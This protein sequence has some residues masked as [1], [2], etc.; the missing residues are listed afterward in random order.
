MTRHSRMGAFVLIATLAMSSATAVALTNLTVTFD[1]TAGHVTTATFTIQR[2]SAAAL[3]AVPRHESLAIAFPRW[4]FGINSGATTRFTGFLGLATWGAGIDTRYIK[5]NSTLLVYGP[6]P[7][8]TQTTLQF[9]LSNI[10]LPY[11]CED[12]GTYSIKFGED[13]P[14]ITGNPTTDAPTGC[15]TAP[16]VILSPSNGQVDEDTVLALSSFDI[17]FEDD[18]SDGIV[19]MTVSTP[20]GKV[21]ANAYGVTSSTHNGVLVLRGRFD[22]IMESLQYTPRKDFNGVDI[23]TIVVND[24]DF[25]GP[26]PART[27]AV[28]LTITVRAVNDAPTVVRPAFYEVHAAAQ[29]PLNL[30]IADV[31]GGNGIVQVS[32]AVVRGYISVVNTSSVMAV[33]GSVFSATRSIAFRSTV[34]VAQATLSTLVYSAAAADHLT[35]YGFLQDTLNVTVNDTGNTGGGGAKI[36]TENP[37][38]YIT[39]PATEEG[40]ALLTAQWL[41]I[42]PRTAIAGERVAF[43]FRGWK[44]LNYGPVAAGLAYGTNCSQWVQGAEPAN[45]TTDS[46]GVTT[47][48]LAP[49]AT[50][51]FY[52]CYKYHGSWSPNPSPYWT[53]AANQVNITTVRDSSV[54]LF[55]YQSC[56]AL[57]QASSLTCGCFL[58][59]TTSSSTGN[60]NVPLGISLLPLLGLKS[61]TFNQGCCARATVVRPS[62]AIGSSLQWGY[63]S[64]IA[65]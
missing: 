10:R 60:T 64:E 11:N 65:S 13:G 47:V 49:N 26:G 9:T 34:A 21:T 19:E 17:T 42:A 31:D 27:T 52:L 63:C 8:A 15:N 35:C 7:E 43:T 62:F 50:G 54:P 39:S 33:G 3:V 59:D 48:T 58:R 37:A 51:F 20:N 38:I 46:F 2:T 22:A 30:S 5:T 14:S 41:D 1:T 40:C 23:I 57:L 55:G 56:N 36:V 29:T 18:I 53:P 32:L 12:P 61:Q 6:F 16:T 28:Q 4:V 45:S 24:L 44:G 25:V